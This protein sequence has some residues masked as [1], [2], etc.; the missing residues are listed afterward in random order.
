MACSDSNRRV[1][2]I[3]SHVVSGYVGNKAAVFPLQLLEFEVDII[4]SVQFSNHTGYPNGWEGDVLD[5]D[6]LLKLVDGLDRNGLLSGADAE[7]G[8]IGH[9]LTGYIGTES[10]LRAVVVVVKKLKD[11]NSKCRF[12]C[13]PVLGDRGK[14]YVPKELVEIYRNEVLPLADVITPNQFEVEQLTG[15]SIHN[16]KDAQSACDILH[17]LGVP[18]VLITSVVFGEGDDGKEENKL[19]TPSNS[20]GMFA[21]RDGA[22]VEQYLLYTPKF[23]GQFTGTGDLC[24]S[25]FLGLTARGD[26]TTR[27]AL[28]KLAGTMH[29]IVKRT[30][31]CAKVGSEEGDTA[32]KANVVF[33]REMKL[34]QSQNDI[35][36]PPRL[37]RAQR[38]D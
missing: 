26:E 35:L 20:I 32:E 29:A 3:Q 5:G 10:F 4:N 37:F 34:V 19:I 13:D 17:G 38:V 30:S 21:S 8:R 22:A 18:L 11:L 6:R 2:S 36:H 28:E 9:V 1:L 33:S 31:Q 23:E 25:L 27:D 12:V 15:I 24:A 14:F 7:S 16:I